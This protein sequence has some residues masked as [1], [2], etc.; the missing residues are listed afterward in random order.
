MRNSF[1]KFENAKTLTN[2]EMD[3]VKG[4]FTFCEWYAGRIQNG[5]AG[6]ND[7]AKQQQVMNVMFFLDTSL[8]LA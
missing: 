5:T 6:T 4:G 8:G 7:P 1:K 2:N 3:A